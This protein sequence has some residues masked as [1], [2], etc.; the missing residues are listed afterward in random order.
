MPPRTA[1]TGESDGERIRV[2]FFGEGATLAH[3]ARPMALAAALPA[4]RYDPVVATPERYHGLADAGLSLLPL[5]AQSPEAF[6]GRLRAGKPVFSEGRL[7]EYVRADLELI[8]EVRPQVVVGDFRLSLA[9]SAK[10]A[11]VPYASISNAYWSPG[12]PLNAKRAARDVFAHWPGF[13]ADAAF[14]LLGPVG[15]AWHAGPME[16]LLLFHGLEGIGKNLQRAFTTADITLYADP[17]SLFPEVA[18]TSGERFLG[19]VVWEPPV[20][21]PAWWTDVPTGRPIAY[22]TLGSSGPPDLLGRTAGWLAELGYTVLVA[23]AGRAPIGSFSADILAAAYLPGLQA[24]R[25][26]DIVVCN[27]GSPTT[28][29]ALAAGRPVLGVT[30]NLDQI[31]NMRAVEATG[32]GLMLRA[33]QLERQQFGRA[34]GRLTEPAFARAAA[35]LAQDAARTNPAATLA[36][37]ID[38]LAK[39]RG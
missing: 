8:A 16:R 2:L 23:T 13:A 36:A 37:A 19:P 6:E 20:D 9:A 3:A 18:E 5:E 39:G 15:L 33:D 29:Q 7:R 22:L 35:V 17:P 31:L 34:V 38:E 4:A 24:S 14:R 1:P 30:S 21:P 11:G 25:R 12:R 27:G 10:I 32:A 28:S 26:A